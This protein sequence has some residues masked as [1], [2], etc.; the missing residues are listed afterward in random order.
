[1]GWV[2]ILRERIAGGADGKSAV[3]PA[4]ILKILAETETD[5]R[6][7]DKVVS[8]FSHVG[9]TPALER[10]DLLP[11]LRSSL[12]YLSRR[13]PQLG[14]DIE[15][16]ENYDPLPHIWMNGE[17]LEWVVE[18]LVKNS[19]DAIDR[20]D[21][22]IEIGARYDPGA[23]QVRVTFKDNGR[24]MAPREQRR[25][26]LP[27]YSTKRRGWGLGLPLAKRIVE[28]YHGG[29]LAL[30]WSGPGAG[31]IFELSLPIA[32][33]AAEGKIAAAIGSPNPRREEIA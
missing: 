5:L 26:F 18:N 2:E 32:A 9:S 24:G 28:E 14:G 30:A 20:P 29:R 23:R 13:F 3:D 12:D 8:R 4:E 25:V 31:A 33:A 6:R 19:L 22:V 21:G 11:V 10:G 15:L 17:L 16:R 1:M 27:G 7:L